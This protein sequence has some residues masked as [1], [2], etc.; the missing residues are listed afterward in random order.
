MV[1]AGRTSLVES[2]R[3]LA[4]LIE[5]LAESSSVLAQNPIQVGGIPEIKQ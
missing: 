5:K 1:F 4:E 3:S 2:L